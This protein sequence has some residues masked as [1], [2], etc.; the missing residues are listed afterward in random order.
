MEI[1][2]Q[3]LVIHDRDA[4]FVF[5]IFLDSKPAVRT[6]SRRAGERPAERHAPITLPSGAFVISTISTLTSK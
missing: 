4:A 6:F 2:R 1:L 3:R 5:E